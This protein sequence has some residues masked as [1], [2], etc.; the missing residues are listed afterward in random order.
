MRPRQTPLVIWLSTLALS[1]GCG[2]TDESGERSGTSARI[3]LSIAV[4]HEP[5]DAPQTVR[6]ECPGDTSARLCS[7]AQRLTVEDFAP[8]PRDQTCTQEYG[9]PQVA[10]I[11]GSIGGTMISARLSRSNGCQI[12]RWDTLVAPF[13]VTP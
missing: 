1:A 11:A 4:V 3:S 6:V 9:G 2:A 8:S 13:F 7:V 12:R 5:G 10:A